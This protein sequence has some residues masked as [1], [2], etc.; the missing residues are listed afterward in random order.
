MFSLSEH[1]IVLKLNHCFVIVKNESLVRS[2]MSW[3]WQI[4]FIEIVDVK[5]DC[6]ADVEQGPVGR[7]EAISYWT[8]CFSKAFLSQFEFVTSCTEI[9]CPE[10]NQFVDFA[11]ISLSFGRLYVIRFDPFLI[12]TD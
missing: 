1:G 7:Q 3:V 11:S 10:Q 5:N 2:T 6:I 8:T 9:L 12:S 4:S